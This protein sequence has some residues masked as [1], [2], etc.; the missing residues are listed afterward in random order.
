MIKEL[1]D[2]L[3][4]KTKSFYERSLFYE[5]YNMSEQ[6]GQNEAAYYTKKEI[7]DLMVENLPDFKNQ[8][9]VT[10]L[11]PSVGSG[12]FIP[13]LLKKYNN[14]KVHL[15]LNDIS[16][17]TL[18]FLKVLIESYIDENNIKNIKIS[19]NLSDFMDF[20]FSKYEPI[21]IIIGNPPYFTIKNK[22]YLKRL[23][24]AHNEKTNNIFAFFIQKSINNAKYTS[25]IIPKGLL[26][27]ANY[28]MTRQTL[29]DNIVNIIDYKNKA[30]KVNLE[31][32]S[33]VYERD[34][35]NQ[36]TFVTDYVAKETIKKERSYILNKNYPIWIIYRNDF[37][38]QVMNKLY[39]DSFDVF[40]DR[41]ITNKMLNSQG[42]GLRVLRGK[43]LTK[44]GIKNIPDYDKYTEETKLNVVKKINF[45]NHS[46]NPVL[47]APNLTTKPRFT[48]LP[49][50]TIVNGSVALFF[51][52]K[53]NLSIKQ[54]DLDFLNSD[55]FV[56]YFDIIRNKSNLTINL[57][58]YIG[59]FIGVLK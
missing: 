9:H 40:R 42:L 45:Y 46:E 53:D 31:T 21:D 47:I 49:E 39:V 5:K 59:Y 52:K 10:I 29:K 27:A 55:E 57:D 38:D 25:F 33:F 44:D 50:N 4:D 37:F 23:K 36:Y 58:N 48:V 30:F 14:K 28:K 43:N 34:Q 1:K 32:I 22:E 13:S 24:K 11:E 2:I 6:D 18:E 17:K 12:N 19:Y 15:I 16:E 8:D 56:K 51:L 35:P 20:D 7:V 26:F 41:Q 54:S 3:Q